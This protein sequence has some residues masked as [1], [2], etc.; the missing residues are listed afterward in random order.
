MPWPY[1]R[2]F[3]LCVE[4]KSWNPLLRLFFSIFYLVYTSRDDYRDQGLISFHPNDLWFDS[5]T[6][7]LGDFMRAFLAV[8]VPHAWG[9]LIFCYSLV[10]SS[11]FFNNI[12]LNIL[13]FVSFLLIR[14]FLLDQ[15]TLPFPW[16]GNNEGKPTF[17][18]PRDWLQIRVSP[19]QGA[20]YQGKE[21]A[22]WYLRHREWDHPGRKKIDFW[23]E[24]SLRVFFL[25]I[26]DC[27]F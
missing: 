9:H 11:H 12:F 3:E 21:E 1:M 2:I 5:F 7:D 17:L 14:P 13:V 25:D 27:I 19:W 26:C 20:P 8:E 16:R 4:H 15:T 24:R 23:W 6:R 22:N 18:V 10:D